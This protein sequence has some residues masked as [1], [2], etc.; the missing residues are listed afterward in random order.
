MP[1]FMV[2][3]AF[4]SHKPRFFYSCRSKYIKKDDAQK[5]NTSNG[6]IMHSFPSLFCC[7]QHG[8][9]PIALQASHWHHRNLFY[10]AQECKKVS[11][12]LMPPY[13]LTQN[14]T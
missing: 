13:P 12:A 5:K 2:C 11:E 1:K 6:R 14:L 4:P 7:L 3:L 8:A 9:R 10:G